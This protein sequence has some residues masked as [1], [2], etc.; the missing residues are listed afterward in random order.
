MIVYRTISFTQII[1][2]FFL[3]VGYI[4]VAAI[5]LYHYNE[6]PAVTSVIAAIFILFL[7]V[8]GRDEIIVYPDIVK[9]NSKSLVKLFRKE[10]T[11]LIADIKSIEIKGNFGIIGDLN[12]KTNGKYYTLN[13]V[14]L[15]FKNGEMY[16]F[17]TSIYIDQL[18]EA[19][20]EIQKLIKGNLK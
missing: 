15:Q 12:Y 14:L 8:T 2:Y 13:Q 16:S 7:I 5:S 1:F 20:A 3:K 10:K 17:K 18:K 4:A 11:F 6:N 9:F 19:T